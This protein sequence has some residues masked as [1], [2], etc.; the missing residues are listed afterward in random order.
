L[1]PNEAVTRKMAPF[2]PAEAGVLRGRFEVA[3]THGTDAFPDDDR[4]QFT[5][6]VEPK[7]KVLVVNGAPNPDPFEDETLYLRA[8]LSAERSTGPGGAP[9]P[10]REMA[11]ALDVTEEPE[12]AWAGLDEVRLK[13]KL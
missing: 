9:A 12:S 8:A 5:L 11:Q 7:L 13:A 10:T 2:I 1:K 3:P 6:Q 4:Y